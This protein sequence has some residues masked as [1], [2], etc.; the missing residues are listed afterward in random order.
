[1]RVLIRKEDKI[2]VG[3]LLEHD[4]CT[5]GR[6]VDEVMERLICTVEL[7]TRER[8]GDLAGL[9]GIEPAPESYHQ[10][11]EDSRRF[12]EDDSGFSLALAA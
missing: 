8:G 7:E 12:Q 11:W 9:A 4:I 10:I 5:Q 6:S 1:M 3:Q 2:F